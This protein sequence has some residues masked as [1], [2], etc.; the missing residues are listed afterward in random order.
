MALKNPQQLREEKLPDRV[1]FVR[2]ELP[3][4]AEELE[5]IYNVMA[6]AGREPSEKVQRLI[7]WV[8]QEAAVLNDPEYDPNFECSECGHGKG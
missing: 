5:S 8:K 1:K 6:V 2:S 3:G 7:V 4:L